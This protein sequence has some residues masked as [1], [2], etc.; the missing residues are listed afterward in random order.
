[1]KTKKRK[2]LD[3]S[4]TL[5]LS[6]VLL[7]SVIIL[8]TGVVCVRTTLSEKSKD[9]D[10]TIM[11]LATMIASMDSTK[12]CLLAGK[13]T[14]DL[15]EH[16]D[17]LTKSLSQVDVIV[18]CNTDSIRLYHNNAE[19][20]GES[21]IGGDEG[22]AIQG[23]PPYISVA[24]GTLG[25]QRRAFHSVRDENGNVIGFVMASSLQSRLDQ[26][27]EELIGTFFTLFALILLIG[28]LVATVF[29][30]A[31]KTLF[32]G[33]RP[34]ELVNLYVERE[35]VLNA[36]E[37]GLLAIDTNHRIIL[38]NHS[39]KRLF[40]LPLDQQMEGKPLAELYPESKLAATMSTGISEHDINSV[41]HRK[42]ILVSRIPL[43][44][45]EKLIGAISVLRNR[46]ELKRLAEEL[47][48]TQYV[49]D[50]LRAVNHE[51][52]NKLHIILGHLEMGNTDAAKQ[53][54]LNTSLVSGAAVSDIHE[55]VPIPAL[56]ALLI[57]KLLRANELG[58]TFVLKQDSYFLPKETDLPADCYVTLV[59]NLVENALDELNSK[60]F[61]IKQVEVGIYSEEGHTNIVC[62]DTGGG[63]PEEIL[64]SI[65]DT[66]TTTKGVGHGNGYYIMKQLVDRYEGAFHID[67]EPGIGTSIE[68]NLPI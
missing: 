45:G 6:V 24:E 7:I 49:V 26:V 52:M 41:I 23:D 8:I 34:E 14:P 56:A 55:R 19:R 15:A 38:M 27:K 18:V 12:E 4:L 21:F 33:F 67:T 61:P 9:Q 13:L 22:P 29:S 3:F 39:A 16:L 48:G 25:M 42:D 37:E 10:T 64:F 46:T 60:D 2:V 59:G 58:I 28:M 68:I 11:D 65:Y 44:R 47:T 17:M 30:K 20:I 66:H 5:Y 43:R 32:L 1:M 31:I 57:G 36:M 53:F 35:E 50:T 63:I 51:F 54:I 40:D 62:D